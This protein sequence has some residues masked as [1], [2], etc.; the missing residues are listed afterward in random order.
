MS[1]ASL[2]LLQPMA[3]PMTLVLLA[4]DC[5]L[6]AALAAKL[7]VG[8]PLHW[9]DSASPTALDAHRRAGACIVLLDYRREQATASAELGRQLQR[10][11]PELPLVAVGSTASDQVDGIVAAVRAGLRD[12]LDLESNTADID[13]VLRRAAGTAGVR[14]VPAEAPHKARLVLVLGARAGVGSS[15]LAAHVGVLAQQLG[16]PAAATALESDPTRHSNSLL[17]L[18][19]G[20]PA[21]DVALYLNLD[22]QFH[23]DDALRNANRID[24]T[25]ARTAMTRHPG[26]LALLGQPAGSEA[27]PIADPAVLVQRLRG[28]FDTVL[29]DLG[30][31]PLRQIPRSLLNS[32]DDI[33]LVADQAIGTLVS[34]DLMLKQLDTLGARDGRLQLVVNRH[35]EAGGLAPAQIAQRFALPLLA[36]LPDCNRLRASANHGHLLLHDAPRDPYLRALTPLLARL[37]P[38]VA[39]ALP[40]GWREKLALRLSGLQWKTK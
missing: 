14:A 15:T 8:T 1:A 21:G 24:A 30:G 39:G 31:A 26:G 3:P 19:L 6:L 33:W 2:Q 18:D 23:Y 12:I 40:R 29:C 32:A 36:T 11:L 27:G 13:A 20:Q 34:L 38:A 28:V 9:E 22:S 7:P 5:G 4:P 35:D 25:L 10:S 17:L 37:D 16:H